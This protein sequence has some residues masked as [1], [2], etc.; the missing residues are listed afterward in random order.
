[1]DVRLRSDNTLNSQGLTIA[2]TI[3]WI[4]DNRIEWSNLVY[5]AVSRVRRIISFEELLFETP[6]FLVMMMQ[7][8]L[9]IS[10]MIASLIRN[11][12][13]I[14]KTEKNDNLILMPK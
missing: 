6:A 13:V 2:D 12:L 1:M 10:L 7:A 5:L 14:N 9:M 4:V 3:V 8:S 11:S